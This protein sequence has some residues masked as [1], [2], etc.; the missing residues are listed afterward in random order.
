MFH[1]LGFHVWSV[2]WCPPSNLQGSHDILQLISSQRFAMMATYD[3][4]VQNSK[5]V[6]RPN[7]PNNFFG[8]SVGIKAL[9]G[10]HWLGSDWQDDHGGSAQ[11]FL[12]VPVSGV[13]EAEWC[14]R[15]QV[16]EQKIARNGRDGTPKKRHDTEMKQKLREH[17]ESSGPWAKHQSRMSC[18]REKCA[19]AWVQACVLSAHT[20]ACMA[21]LL[22]SGSWN[23]QKRTDN[24][25][26]FSVAWTLLKKTTVR[27]QMESDLKSTWTTIELLAHANRFLRLFGA[28]ICYC[29]SYLLSHH[30][31]SC[32]P[33]ECNSCH[34]WSQVD[35]L[36]HVGLWW[37]AWRWWWLLAL[38][39]CDSATYS[40]QWKLRHSNNFWSSGSSVLFWRVLD[41]TGIWVP[42]CPSASWRL[43]RALV[44]SLYPRRLHNGL[45]CLFESMLRR[46]IILLYC[47]LCQWGESWLM[48]KCAM[49]IEVLDPLICPIA[50]SL[51]CSINIVILPPIP[52]RNVFVFF[53]CI[54]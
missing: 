42:S 9:S 33:W 39:F 15:E 19:H 6:Q 20:V 47:V 1:V 25:N 17:I 3:P 32:H 43:T 30:F 16:G 51:R 37:P 8:E 29:H 35:E 53:R 28:C 41:F 22:L 2:W 34:F 46:W 45:A 13:D 54:S 48:S 31:L 5:A 10:W 4:F 11:R 26:D 18:A 12:L 49:K 36:H 44:A 38:E 21:Y 24:Y 40:A 14:V 7:I 52:Y 27:L 50:C 23:C